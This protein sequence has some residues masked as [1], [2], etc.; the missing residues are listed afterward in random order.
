MIS[1][2]LAAVALPTYPIVRIGQTRC[3]DNQSEIASPK[4]GQAFYG[5]DVQYPG[6]PPSYTL[7]ADGLIVHDNVTCGTISPGD[8]LSW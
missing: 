8:I 7:S 1:S 4:P 2:I 6:K 3:Y 5:Q